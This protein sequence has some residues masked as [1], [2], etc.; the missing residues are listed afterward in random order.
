MIGKSCDTS[1]VSYLQTKAPPDDKIRLFY[2]EVHNI[3]FLAKFF[4]LLE[5][6]RDRQKKRSSPKLTGTIAT[7]PTEESSELP[8]LSNSID[9]HV[10]IRMLSKLSVLTC[11]MEQYPAITP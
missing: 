11:D 8:R 6:K 1:D 5:A 9:D 4:S 10:A 2:I 3:R 7:L